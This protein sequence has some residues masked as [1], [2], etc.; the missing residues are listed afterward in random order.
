GMLEAIPGSWRAATLKGK[1]LAEGWG[2]ELGC[3]GIIPSEDG[4]VI[5]GYVFSSNQLSEHWTMLD[6]FEGD[7]YR[8]VRVLVEVDGEEA[9]EAFVYALNHA[10]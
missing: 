7:G 4:D 6:K 10:A 2:S 1:L 8:R 3:P 5:E 9:L